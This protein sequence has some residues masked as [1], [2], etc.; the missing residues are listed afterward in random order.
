MAD[1][2]VMSHNLLE[3]RSRVSAEHRVA[4]WELDLTVDGQEQIAKD[5]QAP[6]MT[7]SLL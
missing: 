3:L 7:A 5:V 6:K 2:N 4:F 1:L